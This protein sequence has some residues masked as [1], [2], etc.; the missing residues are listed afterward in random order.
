MRKNKNINKVALSRIAILNGL[1]EK[2]KLNDPL[3]ARRYNIIAESIGR[4]IDVTLPKFVKRSY[5]KR[6]KMPYTVDDKIRLKNGILTVTCSKCGD[7]RR[8]PYREK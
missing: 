5:C 6:C 4:R 2:R 1:M 3:L 8:I 7:I